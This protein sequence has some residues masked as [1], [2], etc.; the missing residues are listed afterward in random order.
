MIDLNQ[1]PVQDIF[2]AVPQQEARDY[3]K[4]EKIGDGVQGT[5]VGRD[6]NSVN[7]YG[8]P[9]TLVFLKQKDGS[10]KTVSIRHSKVGLIKILDGC[11]LGQV[12]GF[13]FTGEKANPGKQPT[14]FIRLAQDPK[15]V[16]AQWLA[17]QGMAAP[18]ATPSLATATATVAPSRL[19]TAQPVAAPVVSAPVDDTEDKIRTIIALAKSQL[20]AT[21]E[22]SVKQLVME[23]TGLAFININLDLILQRLQTA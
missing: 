9:Q 1:D 12:I 6:D 4:F 18:Q 10:V 23:K 17:E 2:E 15:I 7:G 5:Y 16:D 8:F 19:A 21:D 22:A 11:K 20:G 3:F 13:Q 14:K